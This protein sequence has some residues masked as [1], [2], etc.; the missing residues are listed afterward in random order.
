MSSSETGPQRWPTP[1]EI[2]SISP[3]QYPLG[4]TYPVVRI[5]VAGPDEFNTLAVTRGV[6]PLTT[7]A[8]ATGKLNRFR[9]SVSTPLVL[10]GYD[11]LD[12]RNANV[13]HSTTLS[14]QLTEVWGTPWTEDGGSAFVI[15]GD[16]I[17]R[18]FFDDVGRWT[19][20]VDTADAL[21]SAYGYAQ[22]YVSS[23]VLCW[24]PPLPERHGPPIAH[25]RDP[26]ESTSSSLESLL[27]PHPDVG[28]RK[29][30]PGQRTR[31]SGRDY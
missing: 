29:F 8:P 14:I 25:K 5:P 15:A 24:E 22:A 9:R 31:R 16:R 30:R 4:E 26:S 13:P 2:Y 21:D 23:W 7:Y 27:A 19:L 3:Y 20:E 12:P 10:R 17:V 6:V 28:A 11:Q 18:G 1:A